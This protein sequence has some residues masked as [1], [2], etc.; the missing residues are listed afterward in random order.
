MP[1]DDQTS[2]SVNDE[3]ADE[4]ETY[5]T[6]R[7]EQLETVLDLAR[8]AEGSGQPDMTEDIE[9]V[10]RR[11]DELQQQL[12]RLPNVIASELR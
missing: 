6:T 12:N 3:L 11:L 10:D 9:R 7:N 4:L 5:G 1:R 2:I 8:G